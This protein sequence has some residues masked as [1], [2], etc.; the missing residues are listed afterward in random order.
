M[1]IN[2]LHFAFITIVVAVSTD[3]TK[4]IEKRAL[5]YP[6]GAICGALV[7]VAVPLNL[8]NFNVFL[9]FNFEANYGLPS[10]SSDYTNGPSWV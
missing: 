8:P 5:T 4:S 2:E 3:A 7:A 9:S 10:K 1:L 6:P